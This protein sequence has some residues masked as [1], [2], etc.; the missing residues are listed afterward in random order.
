[1]KSIRLSDYEIKSI[2]EKAKKY[3]GD[4][5]RVLIFRSRASS[6]KINS[7]VDVIVEDNLTINGI[8]INGIKFL[9]ELDFKVDEL[10][11]GLIVLKYCEMLKISINQKS[12]VRLC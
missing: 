3:F 12:G 2:K 11:I 5:C 7:D 8:A 9:A 6:E 1:M 10:K 4:D